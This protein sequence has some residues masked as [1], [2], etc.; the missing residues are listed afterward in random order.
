MCKKSHGITLSFQ[1]TPV[2]SQFSQSRLQFDSKILS[3]LFLVETQSGSSTP[4]HFSYIIL[5]V[6]S[7]FQK[8][9]VQS[10]P[11]VVLLLA[12]HVVRFHCK[13]TE[14]EIF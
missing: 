14:I 1:S 13:V 4:E 5:S 8:F 3:S 6:F 11:V 9:S 12:L 7:L 10:N 2:T